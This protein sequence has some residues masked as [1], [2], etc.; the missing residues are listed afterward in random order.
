MSNIWKASAACLARW[1]AP[2]S[3]PDVDEAFRRADSLKGAARVTGF[4]S[5]EALAHQL[6]SLF[7]LLCT[8]TL[9]V[10]KDVLHAVNG[11][12]D[13]IED[14]V[15]CLLQGGTPPDASR[16]LDELDAL[17][18]RR[19]RGC[20]RRPVGATSRER[21]GQRAGRLPLAAERVLGA[22]AEALPTVKIPDYAT[23]SSPSK[24][25]VHGAAV[26][27]ADTVRLNIENLDRL[28]ESTSQ[29]LTENL[30]QD[31]VSREL[32]TIHQQLA[33]VEREWES[34]Q[35]TSEGPLRRLNV[36]PE[37][38]GLV[39]YLDLVEHEMSALSRRLRAARLLQ[40]RSS[41]SARLLAEQLQADVCRRG[42]CLPKASSRA[43]AG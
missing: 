41:W 13:A 10:H 40:Q 23:T 3:V 34:L 24:K 33:G 5:V 17:V 27:G 28:L 11:T 20:E 43:S 6:E 1:Q 9:S 16:T 21:P 37:F 35:R 8:H 2:G 12:L 36:E 4:V 18:R 25:S 31:S 29:L 26:Q 19:C 30:Q 7:A 14:S 42:W 38:A 22:S 15:A 39:R 32:N